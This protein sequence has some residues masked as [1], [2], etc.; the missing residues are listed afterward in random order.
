MQESPRAAEKQIE[1]TTLSVTEA[2]GQNHKNIYWLLAFLL[3]RI[4][5]NIKSQTIN[6]KQYFRGVKMKKI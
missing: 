1:M 2:G 4:L 6:S 3:L 5:K